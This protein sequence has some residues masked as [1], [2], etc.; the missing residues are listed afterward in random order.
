MKELIAAVLMIAAVTP[1]YAA[2]EAELASGDRVRISIVDGAGARTSLSGQVLNVTDEALT[3]QPRKGA[4]ATVPLRSLDS[5]DRSLGRRSAGKGFLRGA[6][7]GLAA[8]LVLGAVGGA[9]SAQTHAPAAC[10]TPPS[11]DAQW[12]DAIACG[13]GRQ[14]RTEVAAVGAVLLGTTGA[15][16]GGVA[17]ALAPG[18][19]W[20]K[21]SPERVRLSV[22]PRHGGL[23]AAIQISF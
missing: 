3:I 13:I 23:G 6:G 20:Q 16:V 14:S 18:E 21:A 8:G 15:V 2:A 11:G 22:G 4:P 12:L 1:V 7:V 19:R 5:L 9:A 17:G 10:F